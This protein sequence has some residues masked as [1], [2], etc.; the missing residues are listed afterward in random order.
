MRKS[1][2]ELKEHAANIRMKIVQT[3]HHKGQGHVGGSL[4]AAD[5]FTVLF[6][7]QLN[8]DWNNREHLERDRFVLSKGHVALGL[9]C[10][11]AERGLLQDRELE[12]FDDLH[13]RLQAH[14][15]MT[16]L[17]LL[18]M[19]TGSLGQGMS[20]AVGMALGLKL[21]GNTYNVFTL[22]GDGESQEGQIWEA[23]AT[24]TKYKLDNLIVLV[25]KN[26]LQQFGWQSEGRRLPPDTALAQ[27]FTSFGFDVY[28][29]DGH[30]IEELQHVM[31]LCKQQK[32]G[33]PKA[34]IAA[35]VKGKG[36]SFM[37]NNYMWHSKAPNDEELAFA[38][39]QLR[40]KEE[41]G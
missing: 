7:D 28:E 37:E 8:I 41:Q 18:D 36:V 6:F 38:L 11:F 20:A 30:H 2:S 9:Y 10:T 22:I 40:Q 31:T 39:Q 27:K 33:K 13:S 19:S 25:D 3:A 29:V 4:S 24:A 12:T 1:L 32:D 21:I 5:M 17:D 14:P 23:A 15:D 16:K 34:I 26:D 35:T